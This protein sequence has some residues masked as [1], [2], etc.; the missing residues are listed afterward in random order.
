M[1]DTLHGL[2]LASGIVETALSVDVEAGELMGLSPEELKYG[3][4][5]AA[6]GSILQE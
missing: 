2:S 6:E 1:G 5:I 3:S 4:G